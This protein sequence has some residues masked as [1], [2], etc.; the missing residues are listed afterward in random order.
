MQDDI[1]LGNMYIVINPALQYFLCPGF[2]LCLKC[3]WLE[4]EGASCRV[5]P[6]GWGDVVRHSLEK[7]IHEWW[8]RKI[9]RQQSAENNADRFLILPPV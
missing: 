6:A 8:S 4:G 9:A 3:H 5:M 1:C 2:S 7:S